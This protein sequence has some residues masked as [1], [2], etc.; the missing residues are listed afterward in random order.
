MGLIEWIDGHPNLAAWVQA[1][2]AIVAIGVAFWI[3]RSEVRATRKA[4]EAERRLK[5]TSATSGLG[6]FTSRTARGVVQLV[7]LPGLMVI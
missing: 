2:G 1:I 3:S 7:E 4:A 5:A 6:I